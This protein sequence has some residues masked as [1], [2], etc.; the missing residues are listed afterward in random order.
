MKFVYGSDGKLVPEERWRLEVE[1]AK[2]D[3]ALDSM[4]SSDRLALA[5]R[6]RSEWEKL[7]TELTQ[8]DNDVL[9]LFC[10]GTLDYRHLADYFGPRLNGIFGSKRT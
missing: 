9:A 4:S 10:D 7:G 8:E 1:T 2:L 6:L 5:E 3:A